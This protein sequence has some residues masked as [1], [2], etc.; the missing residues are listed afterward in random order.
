MSDDFRLSA[1]GGWVKTSS[2]VV[3]MATRTY[4]VPEFHT[5]R[6]PRQAS[7]GQSSAMDDRTAQT[8][9][10]GSSRFPV[11]PIWISVSISGH[12]PQS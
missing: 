1:A 5:S 12:T 3:A 7:R 9:L 2:E 6:P 4:D 10:S 11:G 8:T